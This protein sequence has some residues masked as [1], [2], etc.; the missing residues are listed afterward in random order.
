MS[1]RKILIQLA[2]IMLMMTTSGCATLLVNKLTP[3]SE[4]GA[5]PATVRAKKNTCLSPW[6]PYRG[7]QLDAVIIYATTTVLMQAPL[8]SKS[9]VP[10]TVLSAI[11]LPFSFIADTLILPGT[12]S[13]QL[14]QCIRHKRYKN[15]YG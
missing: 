12:A 3:P 6:H 9:I 8:R 15:K 11:D 5:A 1:P 10:L 4:K 13:R 2:L 14:V 7:T